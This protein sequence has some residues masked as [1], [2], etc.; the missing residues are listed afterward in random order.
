MVQRICFDAICGF[1]CKMNN[2]VY[3]L[4]IKMVHLHLL[5]KKKKCLNLSRNASQDLETKRHTH[6]L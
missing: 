6:V 2:S 5:A 1:C 4:Q 3:L